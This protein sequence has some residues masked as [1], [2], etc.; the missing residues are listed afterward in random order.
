LQNPGALRAREGA[1]GPIDRAAQKPEQYTIEMFFKPQPV[2]FIGIGGIGMSGLAEVLLELGYRVTG[3]DLKRSPTT[4]RL[5]ER[6]AVIWEGHAAEHVGGAKAVVVSSAVRPDNA[7]V[8][9]ARRIGIPVI[10]RG[11]LLAELMRQKYGIAVAGSHGKTTTTSMVAAVLSHAGLDPTV[12]VGGRV[13]MMGGANAHLGKSDYLVVESDE[14]DGSFLK[15][16]PIVAIVTNIDREHL[17]Y[18]SGLEEIRRAFEEFVAKVPF[19]GAAILCLDDDNVQQILPSVNRRTVTYG[20]SAQAALRITHSSAGHMASEFHLQFRGRDLGCFRLSVPGAHNALN[21]AA[22][23]AAGLEL[24]I[25]LETIR[26]GLAEFSGVDRR[27]QVKGS[28]RGITVI[29]D[30]GHH[31]TEIRATLA[32]A[33]D[34]R[35][36]R[37][38]VLFQPHRYTRTDAL[39]DDFAR[40]FHQAD[41][42]HVMDIYAASEPP[43]EGVTAEALTRRIAEFGH[44][45]A[46]YAGT[47]DRGV[48]SA[49]A[50]AG[51]GDAILTMGAGSVYQAGEKILERLR[52]GS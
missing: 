39:M 36:A 26:E 27:F 34:C 46:H 25:P 22:A 35:Y 18:Y 52:S 3:S 51:P 40:A 44:R 2:H 6:G 21:A 13:G 41:S 5:A 4:Q 20:I 8:I 11:E 15:L 32:A 45:G 37:V 49:V 33:R 1:E 29:D 50:A 30:Y 23:V 48:E 42:V 31:P 19:Y 16:A 9:E 17:D 14:S 24:E 28:E 43:I 47:M 38:H 12:V 7:E 10:P